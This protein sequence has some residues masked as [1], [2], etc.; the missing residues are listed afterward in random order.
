MKLCDV[1]VRLSSSH[2]PQTDGSS[3]IMN[4]MI[5]NYLRCYCSFNH[6]D[7]D[8][9]LPSAEFAFNKSRLEATGYTPFELDIGWNLSLHWLCCVYR[10]HPISLVWNGCDRHLNRH[11]L[12]L[13]SPIS[14]HRRG[15]ALTT[16][17]SAN[18]ITSNRGTK[19]GLT[20]DTSLTQLVGLKLQKN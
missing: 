13:S 5:E 3:E 9:L 16:Q 10:L 8:L 4:R 7:W 19:S 18:L 2:H 15:R 17:K 11:W 1:Q 12:M 20:N 14:W 6:Q